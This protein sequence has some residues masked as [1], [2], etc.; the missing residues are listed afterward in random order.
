MTLYK[1]RKLYKDHGVKFK[2]VITKKRARRQETEE[3]RTRDARMLRN[4]KFEVSNAIQNEAEIVMLDESVFSQKSCRPSAWQVK[5]HNVIASKWWKPEQALAVCMAVSEKQ[6][7]I[8]YQSQPRSFKK[9]T[10][11]AFLTELATHL[12]VSKSVIIIDNCSIH[13]A[14]AT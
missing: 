6:G 5:H 4:L 12:E 8:C 1:L 10:F 3:L 13:T 11:Q 7:V 14:A 9:E 2:R